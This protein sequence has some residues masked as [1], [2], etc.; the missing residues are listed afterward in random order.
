MQ[1][2]QFVR[3]HWAE[4]NDRFPANLIVRVADPAKLLNTPEVV[5]DVQAFFTE[6]PIPQSTKTL[7]QVLERQRVNAALRAREE[8]TFSAAL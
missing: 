6:H 3:Q 7:D 2:W 5:A 4:I 8:A 1:A